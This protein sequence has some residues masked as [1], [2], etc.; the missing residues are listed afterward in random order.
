VTEERTVDETGQPGGTVAGENGRAAG[1][2]G[3]RARLNGGWASD[4]WSNADDALEPAADPVVPSWRRPTDNPTNSAW[5]PSRYADLLAPP[6][7]PPERYDPRLMDPP[8]SPIALR[9]PASAPPYPYEGE[10]EDAA[11]PV[12][13][14]LPAIP[15]ERQE[16]QAERDCFG[17]PARP[18]VLDAGTPRNGVPVVAPESW[19]EA[20]A[21][22]PAPT[23]PPPV[24]PRPIAPPPVAAPA[25]VN[26]APAVAPAPLSQPHPTASAPVIVP[27]AVPPAPPAQHA[28]LAPPA[29]PGPGLFNGQSGPPLMTPRFTTPV[30]APPA[31]PPP[32]TPHSPA[33]PPP[34][35]H[36]P[37]PPPPPRAVPASLTS[38]A[39]PQ[40]PQAPAY[41]LPPGFQPPTYETRQVGYEPAQ[42]GYDA[43][44]PGSDSA[45]FGYRPTVSYDKPERHDAPEEE[46]T[47]VQPPS[48]PDP[49]DVLPQRV[50]AEPDVP[51]VP[52]P[53]AVDPPAET[54]EL[55]RIATHL[56]RDDVPTEPR[57]RPEG[58]DVNAVLAAVRGVAGVRDASLRTTPAGAH[59]LRL[60]L[61]DGA[62]P[63][64]VSREVAR[65]LQERL[66]LAA[67]P[68][69][70]SAP[71]PEPVRP[72]WSE[73]PAAFSRAGSNGLP[74]P[75][76]DPPPAAHAAPSPPPDVHR[77]TG[78]RRAPSPARGRASVEPRFT[79][80]PASAPTYAASSYPTAQVSPETAPPRPLPT[81]G[82]SGPRVVIDNVQVSTFG[83]DATVEVRLA[84]GD[85][86]S[87]GFASGPAV[88]AY[89]LRLCAV[90]ASAAVDELLTHAQ[91]RDDRGRCFVEHA[92]V[93]P[94]G[95]CEVAVVVLLLVCGGWVEQLAGSAVV[96][97][98]PR[99]AVVRATLA[100]VNR[101][102]DA[103]L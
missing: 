82:R 62:D 40:E 11:R 67:A 31:P 41:D 15:H 76:A 53:H 20:I 91:R 74:S 26:S 43:G 92:A 87:V 30:V 61:A 85:E 16:P 14:G 97:G 9:P 24:A 52:E 59:S 39:P 42:P 94:F 38:L 84:A 68:Q 100:A 86:R 25:P 18:A 72:T 47:G 63:A 37:A 2:H 45:R 13:R 93:V 78:R 33:P 10:L 57:D 51:V 58:F 101:R 19:R 22:R 77:P 96:A 6:P 3:D 73:Q 88:D 75:W 80:A 89:V 65:L 103:L 56:R 35:S 71:P 23:A 32:P 44:R 7:A 64:W 54:P 4:P 60:D 83:L 79:D 90:A 70:P 69:S 81:G 49:A 27:P 50:P 34:T 48:P 12:E 102:L 28:P 55:A 1:P 46:P 21:A 17:D 95:T 29:P 36:S 99:Q 98:D 8:T 5:A 66:G